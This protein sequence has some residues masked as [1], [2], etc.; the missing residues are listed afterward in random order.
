MKALGYLAALAFIA[1]AVNNDIVQIKIDSDTVT[2][3]VGADGNKIFDIDNAQNV[4]FGNLIIDDV[5]NS[6][7]SL[8][9]ILCDTEETSL[10]AT[11]VNTDKRIDF[12]S[13]DSF[14]QQGPKEELMQTRCQGNDCDDAFIQQGPGAEMLQNNGILEGKGN[15]F[16]ALEENQA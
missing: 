1:S 12:S 2:V 7:V 15:S 4:G 5:K 9:D 10:L 11:G 8:Q 16:L 3:A 14:I 6:F 13:D